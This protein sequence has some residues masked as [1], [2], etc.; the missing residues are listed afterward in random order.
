MY[1]VMNN[2]L[3]LFIIIII[4]IIILFID[5][6]YCIENFAPKHKHKISKKQKK[7]TFS[8][9]TSETQSE[10]TSDDLNSCLADVENADCSN[11]ANCRT[12]EVN[13]ITSKYIINDNFNNVHWIKYNKKFYL[14]KVG[15]VTLSVTHINDPEILTNVY[16]CDCEC[17][18]LIGEGHPDY[19]LDEYPDGSA[20]TT[21]GALK[22]RQEM[23][24]YCQHLTTMRNMARQSL[25]SEQYTYHLNQ[26]CGGQGYASGSPC[27]GTGCAQYY[28]CACNDAKIDSDNPDIPERDSGLPGFDTTR[29]LGWDKGG[30]CVVRGGGGI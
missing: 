19:G 26:K 28:C 25:G 16:Y 4:F 10:S 18:D 22:N 20:Q 27:W 17:Q 6:N 12:Q 24:K 14:N 5:Y 8:T 9:G 21:P 23:A 7:E 29:R 15:G 3:I 2:I 13:G 30:G 1:Y 11:N